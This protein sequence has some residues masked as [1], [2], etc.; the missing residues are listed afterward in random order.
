MNPKVFIIFVCV[1]FINEYCATPPNSIVIRNKRAGGASSAAVETMKKGLSSLF[2]AGKKIIMYTSILTGSTLAANEAS[3]KI[4]EWRG[5]VYIE[6]AHLM[7]EKNSF[8]CAHKLCWATCGPR[9]KASDWCWT[10]PPSQN[11]KG[12]I[13]LTAVYDNFTKT[14][15]EFSFVPCDKQSDCDPCWACAGSCMMSSDVVMNPDG[16]ISNSD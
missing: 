6:R 9:M 13:L 16:T 12:K 7:C 15:R 11:F 1:I 14:E 3:K 5:A 8:G 2:K 4:D 10:T